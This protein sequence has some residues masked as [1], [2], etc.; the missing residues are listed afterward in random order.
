MTTWN[1][2]PVNVCRQL[3]YYVD[4]HLPGL[5]TLG[6]GNKIQSF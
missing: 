5:C 3:L 1:I 6:I 4:M 2:F